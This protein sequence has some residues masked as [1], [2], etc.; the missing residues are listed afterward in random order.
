MG[1]GRLSADILERL[2]SALRVGPPMRLAVL[3]GSAARGELRPDSDVDIAILPVDRA[4]SLRA[5]LDLQ[6]ALSRACGRDVDL[7]RLD[8]ASTL[9]RWEVARHAEKLWAPHPAE[10]ARFIADAASE[11]LDFA[12]AFE[13]AAEAFR[14][15]LAASVQ[16]S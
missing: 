13:R 9:V 8:L 14:R 12:P 16:E 5:E 1:Y 15:A 2:R 3:F 10:V 7:V 11:Y 4:L 6:V